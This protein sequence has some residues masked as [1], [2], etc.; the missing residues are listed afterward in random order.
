M[1]LELPVSEQDMLRLISDY[2]F[3]SKYA[4]Y[5]PDKKRRETWNEA[6][7][8]VHD[9]HA[10]KFAHLPQDDLSEIRW[11]FDM[12]KDRR[13]LPS[14]RSLQFGGK[15]I[16]AHHEKIYNCAMC[17]V[18]SMKR[19]S[20]IFYMLLCGCGVGFSL[21][22]QFIDQ[23]PPL[24]EGYS[25]GTAVHVIG[26]SIEGWADSVDV[27]LQ[28]FVEG[29]EWSGKWV[30]FDASNVREEGAPIVTGGGKAP[31][32]AGLLAALEKI[33]A[34]LWEVRESG[35]PRLRSIHC[36]DIICHMSDAVLSG[37]VRRSATL[38]L[39]APDDDE[40]MLAKT[41]DWLTEN[42]QRARS[43]NSVML[44]RNHTSLEQFQSIMEATREWGEPGFVFV[45]DL[46]VVINPCVTGD[47][48]VMTAGGPRRVIDLVGVHTVVQV[49]GEY[50]TS[51]NGFWKTGTRDVYTLSTKEGYSL[52]LT[53]NHKVLLE[54]GKW[55]EAG[56]LRDGD[57]IVL[58][59]HDIAPSWGGDGSKEDGYLV[60]HFLGDGTWEGTTARLCSWG[61]NDAEVAV[62]EF[63]GRQVGREWRPQLAGSYF[64]NDRGVVAK[65]LEPRTK[66]IS[67]AIQTASSAFNVGLL[68]GLFDTD[69]HVEGSST[70]GGISIRLSQSNFD[71]LAD[72]QR[73]LLRMGI[74]SKINMAREAGPRLLPNGSGELQ[75]YDCKTSWRLIITSDCDRFMKYVGFRNSDKTDK[76]TS[77]RSMMSRGFYE[78]PFVATF[79][80]LEHIGEVDVYDITVPDVHAFDA[81]GLYVHNCAE[82]GVIPFTDLGESGFQ[83]CNLS[84]V[85]GSK[86]VTPEDFYEAAKAAAI[87]GT[88]QASYTDFTYLSPAAR[89]ITEK[90]AL[91]GVSITAMMDNP[92][93]LLSPTHQ[94]AAADIVVKTNR[95]WAAKLGINP[96]PRCCVLKPEGTSTLAV[97]SMASGIHASKHRHMFRRV[98]ANKNEPV[99]RF[100]KQFNPAL[101]EPS[102][103]S[104][105]DTDDVITFPIKV[106][107]HAIIQD[108]LDAI[109]HLEIIKST[110]ANWVLPGTQDN[111]KPV[112]HNISAT[113]TVRDDEWE[114]VTEFLYENRHN[115]AAV[116]FLSDDGDTKYEQAP[117]QAVRT[118]EDRQRFLE[119]AAQVFPID[120]ELMEEHEDNTTHTQEAS[121]AGGS[122]DLR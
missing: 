64:V 111:L 52:N 35:D 69:G 49:D 108:D 60:G 31:G 63:I 81:N 95:R 98:Q 7:D 66:T 119:L 74:R 14:M 118:D 46:D 83:M 104:A 79:S 38:A 102:V 84:T 109:S 9:M 78:K 91:L 62:R 13:A 113:V 106:A 34:L 56:D 54:S 71:F 117:M 122:C 121:C 100:F 37:G 26:D 45:D 92:D 114:P 120:Y 43:N 47:T 20:E 76:Y 72:V 3:T 36:Y 16:E 48:W 5:L 12:V 99:Y 51:P 55:V 97:R 116:S 42:P 105:N 59:N 103:W 75:A 67:D 22:P 4:R 68:Q 23:L 82:V 70:G 112:T 110:Y 6:V 89:E 8:R 58:N 53:T 33:R 32:P 107:D 30:V 2:V 25:V 17:H 39:F 80:A 65:Y 101:C 18:N 15:A 28:S 27:L 21:M 41:G 85:V 86:V 29:N 73:I 40:M 10:R 94:S 115:Y 77:I 44:L 93:V 11:A 96:S 61:D 1:E 88:L 24:I 19:F 57:K 50:H 90:E 87:I